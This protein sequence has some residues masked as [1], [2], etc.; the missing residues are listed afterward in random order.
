M[1]ESETPPP[2]NLPA[3]PHTGLGAVLRDRLAAGPISVAD[4]MQL[5]LAHPDHGYYRTRD[6]LGSQGDFI[7][8][9]EISQMFGELI[10]I[11]CAHVWGLIGTPNPI[12]LVELG[13]GRG[14][15]MADALRA[16]RKVA[17]RFTEAAEV[18][19]IETSPV[20]RAAQRTALPG[21]NV[22]WHDTLNT[23]P[24][25]GPILVIGN[26]FLDALPIHQLVRTAEG[27]RER[28]VTLDDQGRLTYAIDAHPSPLMALLDPSASA[29]MTAEGSIT[30]I[31]PAVRGF[32]AGLGQ[33]IA[34]QG[35]A[36]LLIDYGYSG[37]ATGDSLQAIRQHRYHPVLADPGE[38]D[39][40][41]HVDF[42]AVASAAEQAGARAH[43]PVEQGAFLRRLGIVERSDMLMR[44]SDGPGREDIARAL[45]RLIGS[46][47]MGQLF[48]VLAIGPRGL[49]LLPGFVP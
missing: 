1:S 12:R 30:E 2:T 43:G 7:T 28:Q 39:L 45:H 29:A 21:V 41:A 23:L 22:T 34:R 49:G 17:A 11:W 13:P 42:A 14:T 4:Y 35:G 8:A 25:D 18:H 9:P 46:D 19:L 37:P 24:E 10:G 31:S 48:K 33:R 16:C 44:A 5:A 27:W 3:L 36:A 20:L 40:T 38:A 6:P 26:E 47:Q 32:A 15:L